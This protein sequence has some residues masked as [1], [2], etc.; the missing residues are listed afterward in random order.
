M[1]VSQCSNAKYADYALLWITFQAVVLRFHHIRVEEEI[2][3][4]LDGGQVV[5]GILGRVVRRNDRR[6]HLGVAQGAY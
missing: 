3:S 6:L 2:A 5:K 4:M 1:D